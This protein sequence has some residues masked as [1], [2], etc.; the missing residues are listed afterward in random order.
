MLYIAIGAAM[1]GSIG[2]STI[3]GQRYQKGDE[4]GWFAFG[5]T[6]LLLFPHNSVRFETDLVR[7]TKRSI[8]TYV[9][10][11]ESIAT[12]KGQKETAPAFTSR[13]DFT[14]KTVNPLHVR[15]NAPEDSENTITWFNGMDSVIGFENAEDSDLT[16]QQQQ[17]VM[18]DDV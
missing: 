15:A 16:A 4:H 8:E 12:V 5:S 14:L 10:M 3:E 17:Y 9:R 7:N 13:D 11:G 2:L 1:V 18:N 6:I